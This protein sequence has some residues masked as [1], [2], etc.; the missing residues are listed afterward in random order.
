M[1]SYLQAQGMWDVIEL[2]TP[3]REDMNYSWKKRNSAVLHTIQ[4]SCAPEIFDKIKDINVA[5]DVWEKL[6]KMNELKKLWKFLKNGS[7]ST[8]G[9]AEL[10]E[11]S[12]WFQ[13]SISGTSDCIGRTECLSLLNAFMYRKDCS[14][15]EL[16]EHHPL[17]KSARF[18]QHGG[19]LL[20]LVISLKDR[21]KVEEMVR[22]MSPEELEIPG[23]RGGQTA[24]SAA[25]V[26]GFKKAAEILVEKNPRLLTIPDKSGMIPVVKACC[27]RFEDMA[28]FLYFETP[29]ELLAPEKGDHGSLLLHYC[30]QSKM[31][32]LALHLLDKYPRLAF[33]QNNQGFT[34]ILTLASQPSLFQSRS[35]FSFWQRWIYSCTKLKQVKPTRDVHVSNDDDHN[36]QSMQKNIKQQVSCQPRGWTSILPDIFGLKDIHKKKWIHVYVNK[37]LSC[38]FNELETLS[39]QEAA[40]SGVIPAFFL[41]AQ[42]G[43]IEFIER[44]T[45]DMITSVDEN[46]RD[47]FMHAIEYRKDKFLRYARF[48]DNPKHLLFC[49][50]DNDENNV[51][52]MTAK[53]APNSSL[54]GISG[55][56][57]KLQRELQWFNEIASRVPE[58]NELVNHNGETP[59]QMFSREHDKLLKEGEEWMKKTAQSYTVV[60]AL[61][62]T[63]MF[64]AVIT[65]PGGNNQD[66]GL[67][68]FL[69]GTLFTVFILSVGISLSSSSTS[70][71]MFLGIL[72]SRCAEDD[73]LRSLPTKLIIG[74]FTLL[75]SITAMMVAFCASVEI[76]LPG[77]RWVV[78]LLIIFATIPVA[79]FMLL[80][81]RLLFEI[82]RSTYGPNI[83]IRRRSWCKEW[84]SEKRNYLMEKMKKLLRKADARRSCT[85][86][87]LS[88]PTMTDYSESTTSRIQT[89]VES[90]NHIHS[91]T[92]PEL[93]ETLF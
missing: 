68:T 52:H 79:A 33:K 25:V 34:P 39:A 4:I 93:E 20:S 78:I 82:L 88:V 63:I 61:I 59:R 43:I 75:V 51:L 90:P 32:D 3:P 36:E 31:L 14:M 56:A 5:K 71:L 50:R 80:Q 7:Q 18:F 45:L 53:L 64:A 49:V 83:L 8:Q 74:I 87:E 47:V 1:E 86:L 35:E 70:V 28:F 23:T 11:L 66:S 6:A 26:F 16:L 15:E 62:V 84:I 24:L 27:H 22:L 38:I 89:S 17:A 72:T 54:D 81:S 69:H 67:P 40:K 12:Q 77:K 9:T 2:P 85:D 10:A 60:G 58:C 57:L 91:F 13:G 42:H 48:L 44:A 19:T 46:S 30:I 29:I 73:F 21:E 92:D 41:A 37:I 65:V 76:M 55:P